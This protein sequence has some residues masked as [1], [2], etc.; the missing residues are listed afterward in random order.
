[1]DE[2][3]FG[4]TRISVRGVRGERKKWRAAVRKCNI[5]LVPSTPPNSTPPN[6]SSLENR[7]CRRCARERGSTSVAVVA[8]EWGA[9]RGG[10]GALMGLGY[11]EPVQRTRWSYGISRGGAGEVVGVVVAVVGG[12]GW[13]V[14]M[15]CVW[16][17]GGMT[18]GRMC[19]DV[20][21]D[22]H[23]QQHHHHHHHY[24]TPLGKDCSNCFNR[25]NDS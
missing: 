7:T 19:V 13:R 15:I 25:S 9:G 18:K 4:A 20:R 5:P 2:H 21:C 16:G 10:E 3:P 14:T 1:M 17:W 12:G 6:P 24:P 8:A 23:H 11:P 22:A